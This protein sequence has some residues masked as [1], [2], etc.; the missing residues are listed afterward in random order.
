MVII[1]LAGAV[2]F[3]QAL[4]RLCKLVFRA[5]RPAAHERRRKQQQHHRPEVPGPHG[6]AGYAVPPTPIRVTLARDEEAAGVASGTA[7]TKPPAYGLW[8]E[9]VRVDP[10]RIYWQ[11]NPDVGTRA[12]VGVA[13]SPAAAAAA[14]AEENEAVVSDLDDDDNDAENLGDDEIYDV[15]DVSESEGE[16]EV[17]PRPRG[18]RRPPSYVSEDGVSYIMEARPRS[19]APMVDVPLPVHPAEAGR[20]AMPPRW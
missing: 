12:G 14:A 18:L 19:L 16:G 8:R 10:D 7:G 5:P 6:P 20:V 1:I 15:S 9:S 17:R 13:R 2:F 4:A 11:R 3:A